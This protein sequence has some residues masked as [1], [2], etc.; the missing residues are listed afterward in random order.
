MLH[1]T[2]DDLT[3]PR[4]PNGRYA[5]PEEIAGMAVVL[6]SNMGR[7]VVGDTIYMTGGAGLITYDD[8]GPSF[9]SFA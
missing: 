4:L 2:T 7:C 1:A 6:V 9:Y 5:L 3:H 8:V